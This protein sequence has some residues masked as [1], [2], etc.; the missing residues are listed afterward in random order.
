M[1]G[2]FL[3]SLAALSVIVFIHEFGHYITARWSG[4]GIEVFSVGF[5]KILH[6]FVDKRGT[7]WQFCAIPLGGYVHPKDSDNNKVV[8]SKFKEAGTTRG[9]LVAIAGPMFNFISAFLCIAV[10]AFTFGFPQ[11]S[12]KI[13]EILPNSSAIGKL[14]PGDTILKINDQEIVDSLVINVKDPIVTIEREGK[15]LQFQLQKPQS[16]SYKILLENRFQKMGLISAIANA[17]WYV[18]NGIYDSLSRVWKAIASLN[19]MGPIGIMKTG[20]QVQ[21][22]GLAAFIIFIANISIAIGALNL[23]PV[24]LLDGGR[25]L[26]FLISAIIR[27]P[28]PAIYEKGL[29][30]ISVGILAAI[31]A[32]GFF[33][34]I[35]GLIR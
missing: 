31:F 35:K 3:L 15:V 10:L 9:V 12:S 29:V 21:K 18:V 14:L 16:E 6:S 28:I 25:I 23:L 4:V 19:L 32:I 33:V 5:G 17:F 26:I 24:P 22:H 30:Y 20:M 34:D 13:A 7:K 27:R 11:F 1:Y 2:Q 8:G